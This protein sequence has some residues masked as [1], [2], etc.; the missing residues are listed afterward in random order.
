MRRRDIEKDLDETRAR[1]YSIN[2]GEFRAGVCG[3]GAP[4]R[5]RSGTVVAAVGVW[6]AEANILGPR[7]E[8]LARLALAAARDISRALGHIEAPAHKPERAAAVEMA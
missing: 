8:E 3:I 7:R 4:V 1:G 5:D 6:G 2:R